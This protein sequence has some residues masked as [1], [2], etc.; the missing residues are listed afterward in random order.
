MGLFDDDPAFQKLK[1]LRESG[2]DGPVNQ[3]GNP[4][5]EGRAAEILAEMRRRAR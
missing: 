1:A 4:V 2:Y 5:T 3:D